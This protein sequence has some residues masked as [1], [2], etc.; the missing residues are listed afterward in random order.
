MKRSDQKPRSQTPDR[1][2]D[3]VESAT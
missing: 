1:T 3:S 2:F